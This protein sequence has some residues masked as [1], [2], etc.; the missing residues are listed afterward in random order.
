MKF[1]TA[2]K[3]FKDSQIYNIRTKFELNHDPKLWLNDF[4][5]NTFLPVC[6]ITCITQCCKRT[7]RSNITKHTE[8]CYIYLYTEVLVPKLMWI[9]KNYYNI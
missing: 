4:Q 7:Q 1:I 5:A 3:N 9:P 6:I 8:L 2:V